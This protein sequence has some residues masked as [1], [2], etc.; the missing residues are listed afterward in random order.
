MPEPYSKHSAEPFYYPIVSAMSKVLKRPSPSLGTLPSPSLALL[1]P[2]Q[3]QL[4]VVLLSV[5]VS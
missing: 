4:T 1:S 3:K 5:D 2:C